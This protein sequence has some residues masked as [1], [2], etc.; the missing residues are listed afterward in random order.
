VSSSPD[1]ATGASAGTA[2][3][4]IPSVYV[5]IYTAAA[6]AFGVHWLLLVSIHRQETSFSTCRGA[7]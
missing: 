7:E 1:P 5:P 6:E 4:G 3:A 2:P